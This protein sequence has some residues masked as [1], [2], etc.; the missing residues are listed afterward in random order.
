M[1]MIR[2]SSYIGSKCK[3]QA[4]YPQIHQVDPDIREMELNHESPIL[5]N[6]LTSV[7][8]TTFIIV[9][10]SIVTL[11]HSLFIGPKSQLS[12]F[13]CSASSRP[14]F[15]FHGAD[16]RVANHNNLVERKETSNIHAGSTT[17]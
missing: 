1:F 3:C 15:S 5:T 4:F 8:R 13:I 7:P 2:R 14:E 6:I 17:D 9:A 12:L 16:S 10:T 11:Q